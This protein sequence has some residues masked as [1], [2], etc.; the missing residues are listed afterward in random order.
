MSTTDISQN[1]RSK[2]KLAS[3]RLTNFINNVAPLN[4]LEVSVYNGIYVVRFFD[5]WVKDGNFL[6]DVVGTGSTFEDACFDYINKIGGKNLVL[7]PNGEREKRVC[8]IVL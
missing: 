1:D 2:V 3:E 5:S 8:V 7:N 6:V 4:P